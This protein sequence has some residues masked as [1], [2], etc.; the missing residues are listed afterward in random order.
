MGQDSPSMA[1]KIE[2]LCT[3]KKG[4]GERERSERELCELNEF[5]FEQR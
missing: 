5:T 3:K 4:D 2:E 1:L